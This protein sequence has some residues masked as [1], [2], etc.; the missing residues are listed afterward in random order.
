MDRK[1]VVAII[2][3]IG[4]ASSQAEVLAALNDGIRAAASAESIRYGCHVDLDHGVHPDGCVL[5]TGDPSLCIYARGLAD[6][7]KTKWSCK[8]WK[9]I[10]PKE[11][12]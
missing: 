2:E 4:K 1:I 5:D 3:N 8:W 10:L 7:G 9:P 12:A 11:T 6:A